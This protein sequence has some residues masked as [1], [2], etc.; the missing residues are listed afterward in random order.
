M[1]LPSLISALNSLDI[2]ESS[3]KI[4]AKMNARHDEFRLI[5]EKTGYS[6]SDLDKVYHNDSMHKML[7]CADLLGVDICN[8]N[9]LLYLIDQTTYHHAFWPHTAK[10]FT[11]LKNVLRH[12]KDVR[13]SLKDGVLLG[14]LEKK[15]A[16][17]HIEYDTMP[18][19]R[20]PGRKQEIK[21]MEQV[22]DIV[23]KAIDGR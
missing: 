8:S 1:A 2:S 11:A 16:R 15:L 3:S 19:A 13:K 23:K 14:I 4:L 18:L 9:V 12:S 10:R 20:T 22:V 6:L 21:N 5:N 7:V 17:M